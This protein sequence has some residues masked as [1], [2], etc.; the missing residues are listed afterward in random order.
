MSNDPYLPTDFAPSKIIYELWKKLQEKH[1]LRA[2][3]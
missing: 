1:W 2:V 3:K